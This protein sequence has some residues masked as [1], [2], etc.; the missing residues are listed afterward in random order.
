MLFVGVGGAGVAV[1]GGVGVGLAAGDRGDCRFSSAT[2]LGLGA[3]SAAGVSRPR[4]DWRAC[5]RAKR[6]LRI[7]S[8]SAS[9]AED[10]FVRVVCEDL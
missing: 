2:G 7:S 4:C 9:G 10:M 3:S 6:L 5:R 8:A 1:G